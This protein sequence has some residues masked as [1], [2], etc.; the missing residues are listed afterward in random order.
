MQPLPRPRPEALPQ[1][2]K[3]N[4]L[5]LAS[6]AIFAAVLLPW[7]LIG[8]LSKIAGLTVSVGPAVGV[9]GLSLGAFYAWL[10]GS[11]AD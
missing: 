6:R 2:W 10:P 8:G 5:S 7:F 9:L 1:G 11:V 3:I 4:G